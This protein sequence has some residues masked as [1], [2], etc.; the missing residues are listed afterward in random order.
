MTATTAHANCQHPSTKKGRATCRAI[1]T[2]LA[3]FVALT[4][5]ELSAAMRAGTKVT[6]WA[7]YDDARLEGVVLREITGTLD[8]ME[9]RSGV[10]VWT[11][12]FTID[13]TGKT[14]PAYLESAGTYPTGNI[15]LAG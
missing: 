8:Y 11:I 13:P 15:R 6:G 9:T 3:G 14:C 10:K 7:K 5:T 4:E 1:T 12:R 2:R